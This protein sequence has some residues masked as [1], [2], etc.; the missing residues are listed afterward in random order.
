[1]TKNVLKFVLLGNCRSDFFNELKFG[2]N[3]FHN[4]L[5]LFDVLPNFSF[6]KSETICDYYLFTWYIRVASQVAE[7]VRSYDLR[8]FGNIRK[9]SKLHRMIAP[10]AQFSCQYESFVNTRRKLL[11]K[12]TNLF[13]L[14]VNSH[15]N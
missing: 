4:I 15:E 1:M 9:A 11:K 3:Q 14:C 5:R 6:T 2:D 8:K 13:L 12:E 10:G 7:R